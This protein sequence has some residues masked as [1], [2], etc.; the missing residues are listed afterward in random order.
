MPMR[1][2]ARLWM[3]L[4]IAVGLISGGSGLSL[5]QGAY[6]PLG[7]Y[8]VD[9]SQVSVSGFS[10]GADMAI[11]LGVAFAS[12][13]MGVAAFAPTP[14]DCYRPAGVTKN[15]CDGTNTPDI[16]PLEANMRR[17]SGRENDSTDF[18]ARQ[19]VFMFVGTSDTVR[20]MTV[21]DRAA[22]LYGRF[23]PAAQLRVDGSI[24][25]SHLFPTDFD[26][27]NRYSCLAGG[28]L[29]PP[30]AN[31]GYDGAGISLQWIYGPLA[32]RN[33]GASQGE[34]LSF[35]QREFVVPGRGMDQIGFVYL[36]ASCKAGARCRLHVFLHGCYGSFDQRG[37]AV[38]AKYSGHSQWADTNGIVLLFPQAYREPG[39]PDDACFDT[40]GRYDD[41]YDQ[42]AGTQ[43]SAIMAMVAKITS[44]YAGPARAIEYH[45][46]EW[47]HYFVT[48][49][50]A[51][52]ARLDSGG[53][54]GWARTGESV[55]VYPLDTA[56]TRNV[57]RFFS[58]SFAPR[59]SHF[60]TASASECAGLKGSPS[61]QYEDNV[62]AFGAPGDDG[63]CSAAT[64][65]IYRLYNAGQGGAPNHRYTTSAATRATMIAAGWIPEG[66]GSLGVVGCA[67]I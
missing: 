64:Q 38:Y 58:T 56:G 55:A 41:Q 14:Y 24:A 35:D 62:F 36:P 66:S 3:H 15:N 48:A 8:N 10:A 19:R 29:G 12:K 51:E 33:D 39:R 26:S 60:Y 65:P 22:S 34:I 54:A 25:A 2:F 4:G 50:A 47:D 67:P 28:L 42:K 40:E 44:G 31:C 20:S 30:F 5:A 59:S 43:A 21:V 9:P 53:F 27:P 57:C 16:A 17:W 52:I 11:Q 49:E 37:D 23:V 45:H 6:P 13:I 46:A 7:A 18:L 61:W 63:G 32:P 1:P